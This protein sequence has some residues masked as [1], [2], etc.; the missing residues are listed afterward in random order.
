M[1]RDT[2][3]SGMQA[4][5]PALSPAALALMAKRAGAASQGRRIQGD[6]GRVSGPLSA[7]QQMVWLFTQL[8]PTS[9]AYNRPMALRLIGHV[10]HVALQRALTEIVRRHAVLRF[11][12]SI[13]GDVPIQNTFTI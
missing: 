11:R 9:P 5:E 2:L 8:D 12:I 10:D 13:E 7:G 1:T 4:D 3:I 6:S